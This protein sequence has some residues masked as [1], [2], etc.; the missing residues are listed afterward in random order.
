MSLSDLVDEK[1]KHGTSLL[2]LLKHN[3]H[4]E[5]VSKISR[6]IRQEIKFL[7]KV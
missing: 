2:G 4:L 6:K 7:E 1:I 5:G 3:E